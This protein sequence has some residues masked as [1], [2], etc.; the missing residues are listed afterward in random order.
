MKYIATGLF[1]LAYLLAVA[2]GALQDKAVYPSDP[3]RAGIRLYAREHP[4][5]VAGAVCGIA[6]TLVAVL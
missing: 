6:G 5:I 4:C 1:V 2:D 3:G